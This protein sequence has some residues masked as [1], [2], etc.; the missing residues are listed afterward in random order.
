MNSID[1]SQ[2]IIQLLI[3]LLYAIPTVLLILIILYYIIKKGAKI[4]G[5][6]MLIGNIIVLIATIISK[7][8]FI[9]LVHYQKWEAT[10]YSY[11][12]AVINIISFIGSLAFVIG[13]LL[14]IRK[15]VKNKL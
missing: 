4:D 12:I 1:S 15:I 2:I 6:L 9:Q 11:M 10:S 13:L 5:I 3:A 14:L 8:L 7:I